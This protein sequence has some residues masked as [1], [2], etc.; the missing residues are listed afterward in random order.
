MTSAAKKKPAKKGCGRGF[1]SMTAEEVRAHGRKGGKK[2]HR[3][4]KAHRYTR[5]EA[6]IA[7]KKS[8]AARAKRKIEAAMAAD[9]VVAGPHVRCIK[10]GRF[11]GPKC[12]EC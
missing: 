12:L 6:S 3:R 7:G 1:A 4:K 11:F 2:A 8:A 5:A 10:H 9:M